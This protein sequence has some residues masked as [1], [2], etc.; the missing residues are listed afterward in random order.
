MMGAVY[1]LFSLAFAF[2]CSI[3]Y[4]CGNDAQVTKQYTVNL[5]DEPED[6]WNHVIKDYAA[7]VPDL[8][9]ALLS[10]V[11]IDHSVYYVLTY[12]YRHFMVDIERC[13]I[14]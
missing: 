14:N 8:N 13:C 10:V 6:R 4:G 2:L 3:Q 1:V 9:E 12:S 7:V 11:V 5:D